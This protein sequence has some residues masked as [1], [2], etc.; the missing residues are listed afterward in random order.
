MV[1]LFPSSP[2][3]GQLYEVAPGQLYEYSNITRSWERVLIPVI[4]MASPIQDGLMSSADYLKLTSILLDPPHI[5]L[6][7]D[8]CT[9]T[10]STGFVDFNGD[11]IVNITTNP[12]NITEN[13]GLIEFNLDINQ[14]VN[15]LIA[16]GQITFTMTPG[17]QGDPGDQGDPGLDSLPVGPYGP[18][19]IPGKNVVWPGALVQDN[20]SVR[21]DNRAI[22]DVTVNRVSDTENYLVATRANI[23]NPNACPNTIQPVNQQSPWLLA[24]S[25]SGVVTTQTKTADGKLVCSSACNSTLF[26]L[27]IDTIVQSI[28]NQFA[29]YLDAQKVA[30]EQYVAEQLEIL[31]ATFEEQKAAIACALERVKS[32]TRNTQA[33]QY[34]EQSKIAAAA[35]DASK[36]GYEVQTLPITSGVVPGFFKSCDYDSITLQNPSSPLVD[37]DSLATGPIDD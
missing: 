26:Y 17:V 36:P 20:L 3:D 7:A 31:S 6:S 35:A 9:S 33:R 18:N 22:I 34:L 5:S 27:N 12:D 23:G 28:R 10:I 2:T 11:G 13:T 19:G 1:D 37:P 30:K 25:Q 32:K 14:L 15:S 29:S 24:I 16:G 21:D 4:P 8:G